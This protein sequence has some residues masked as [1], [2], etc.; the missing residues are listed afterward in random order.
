MPS[1]SDP[2]GPS[3]EAGC[4]KYMAN[5]HTTT[6]PV[7]QPSQTP[8]LPRRS[9]RWPVMGARTAMTRPATVMPALSHE[10]AVPESVKTPSEVR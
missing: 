4:T 9:A 8:P 1:A 6:A 2:C 7:N 5:R 3:A 10:L